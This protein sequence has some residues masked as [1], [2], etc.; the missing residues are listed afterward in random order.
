MSVFDSDYFAMAYG[1]N[2][3]RRNPPYKWRSFLRELCKY[4]TGGDLLEAGCG[5]G[6]FLREASRFFNCT[7]CDISE[8]AVLEARQRLPEKIHLFC[9]ELGQLPLNCTYDVIAAF[10]VIEHI[11]DLPRV[12][13]DIDRLLRQ[14]GLLIF[15]VPVYDGPFG[16]LVEHLDLDK[17]HIHKYE[18]DVWLRELPA[19]FALKSYTGVW[20]YFV[21]GR[22]YF[23]WVSR[24]SRRWTTAILVIAEKN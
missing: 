19:Q 3:E 20:R 18:R 4:R 16:W 1:R 8:H 17:T 6:L 23:N 21:L 22:F 7:G 10:D 12:W 2:Y 24:I 5:F 13:S 15:T 14:H 9:G 11:H